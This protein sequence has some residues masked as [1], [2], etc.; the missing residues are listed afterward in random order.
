MP[1][2]A[3]RHDGKNIEP[4]RTAGKLRIPGQKGGSGLS[5]TLALFGQNR[6]DGGIDGWPCLNL[7]ENDGISFKGNKIDLSETCLKARG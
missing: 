1:R 2:A 3:P 4:G 7:D 5:D 6:F